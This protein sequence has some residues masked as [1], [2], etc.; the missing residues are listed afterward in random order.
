M[1][2]PANFLVMKAEVLCEVMYGAPKSCYEK[3]IQY[4]G[5]R[6]L[7][8]LNLLCRN[9]F[10]EQCTVYPEEIPVPCVVELAGDDHVV[11]S[12]FVRRLLEYERQARKEARKSSSLKKVHVQTGSAADMQSKSLEGQGSKPVRNE[13]LDIMWCESFRHGEILVRPGTQDKLFSKM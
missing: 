10:W 8:T 7:F 2:D 12:L 9:V 5:F 1:M 3:L 6:E 11:A 13:P 4:F